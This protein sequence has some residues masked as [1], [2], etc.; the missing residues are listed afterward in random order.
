[1]CPQLFPPPSNTKDPFSVVTSPLTLFIL[2]PPFLWKFF[3]RCCFFL[4]P[5][6]SSLRY[7]PPAGHAGNHAPGKHSSGGRPPSNTGH[8][9][10]TVYPSFS[11]TLDFSHWM[12]TLAVHKG[13]QQ[14]SLSAVFFFLFFVLFFSVFYFVWNFPGAPPTPHTAVPL[15]TFPTIFPRFIWV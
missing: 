4:V 13:L 9:F 12:C 3:F 11:L 7:P 8:F 6:Q 15:G 5:L 2:S 14:A 10:I 1:L